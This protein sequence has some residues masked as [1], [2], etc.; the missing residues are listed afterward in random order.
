MENLH[1]FLIVPF[2]NVAALDEA[3][4]AQPDAIILEFRDNFGGPDFTS[5]LTKGRPSIIIFV[6]LS[7]VRSHCFR[8]ELDIIMPVEPEGILLSETNG[9]DD[10]ALCSARLSVAEA[11]NNL[12][13]GQIRIIA[14]IESNIG[15]LASQKFY[16]TM[17][18]PSFQ[19]LAALAW[20]EQSL[21][22][23]NAVRPDQ[24]LSTA[25]RH[26][27]QNIVFTAARSINLPAIDTASPNREIVS[28]TDE[29]RYA[30]R[31]GY[32]AKIAL[33]P[34]QVQVINEAFDKA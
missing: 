14:S 18:A 16:Q 29:S 11:E 30:A 6:R 13:E 19:R 1:S 33:F 8:Q 25:L 21:R 5:A 23:E 9:V 32:S 31:M 7:S 3:Y 27:Y 20:N 24:P 4:R 17:G 10:I 22:N 34:E 28:F 2:G 12:R 26:H 15:I